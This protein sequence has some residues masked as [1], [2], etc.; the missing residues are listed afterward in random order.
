MANLN[1]QGFG[2]PTIHARAISLTASSPELAVMAIAW[3]F[4]VAGEVNFHPAYN[5]NILVNAK[6]S[7]NRRCG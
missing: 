4:P 5:G 7:R 1:T 3:A 6:D 2:S